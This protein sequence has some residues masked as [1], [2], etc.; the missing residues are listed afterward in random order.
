MVVPSEKKLL[1]LTKEELQLHGVF[2]KYTAQDGKVGHI[3]VSRKTK[4]WAKNNYGHNPNHIPFFAYTVSLL[5]NG[6][7]SFSKHFAWFGPDIKSCSA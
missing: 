1:S 3:Y 2:L 7:S 6:H 4:E 5:G